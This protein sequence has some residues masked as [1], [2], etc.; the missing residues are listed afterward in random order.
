MSAPIRMPT[1]LDRIRN[2]QAQ[3][4]T[5]PSAPSPQ[6]DPQAPVSSA[7]SAEPAAPKATPRS[8]APRI[9]LII[10]PEMLLWLD[11]EVFRRR[12]EAKGKRGY[13]DYT[14]IVREALT[15]YRAQRSSE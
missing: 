14:T 9:T 10:D 2:P 1:L 8:Q 12:R 4:D 3:H 5:Q 11:T 13:A 6:A 7:E 15:A